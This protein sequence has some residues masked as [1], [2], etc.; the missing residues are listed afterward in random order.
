MHFKSFMSEGIRNGTGYSWRLEAGN[1]KVRKGMEISAG[2]QLPQMNSA[3]ITL[4]PKENTLAGELML[5]AE[6]RA[7]PSDKSGQENSFSP[8]P[9]SPTHTHSHTHAGLISTASACLKSRITVTSVVVLVFSGCHFEAFC[10]H[11][12]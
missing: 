4:S 10:P 12:F 1:A 5:N 6:V 9:V 3:H 8:Q 7:E 11:R 2:L